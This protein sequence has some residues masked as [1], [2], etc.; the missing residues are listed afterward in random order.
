MD[1]RTVVGSRR[2]TRYYKPY[3]PVEKEKIQIILEAAR[4]QS[5]HGNASD[6]R[7]AVVITKGETPDD[8]R[9]AL[10]EALYNQPQAAQAPVMIV[11]ACDMTGWQAI[12]LR[13]MDLI[14]AGALNSAYG[15]SEE[16]VD[17]VV[18]KTP[19]FNVCS[20]MLEENAGSAG[21]SPGEVFAKW[22][23]AIECGQAIGS[24]LLAATNEGLGTQLLT[25][26]RDRIR[27]ILGMP[28]TV[29]PTQ[30]QIL[31]YPAESAD[32]GGQRPRPDFESLYFANKWGS[33]L[34]RDLAVT[35]ELEATGMIQ[36]A[37]PTPWRKAE[38]RALSAMFELPE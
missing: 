30:I 13:L 9:D 14:K 28:E 17:T 7:K 38:V 10:I 34:A 4:L 18:M 29:T 36:R 16:F 19:D 21:P 1:F 31:G 12:K 8:V 32:C 6:I 11:W 35:K 2:S 5:C 22:L 27:E 3:Q 33:T 26:K 15:W 24:A 20:Y 23:S 25:G 37:A